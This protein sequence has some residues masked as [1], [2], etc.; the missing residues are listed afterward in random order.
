[1]THTPWPSFR[2][3]DKTVIVTG[4]DGF[5]GRRLMA[6]LR[7]RGLAEQQIVAPPQAE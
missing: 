4:G 6:K 5:L 3:A 1:M 7:E 2:W